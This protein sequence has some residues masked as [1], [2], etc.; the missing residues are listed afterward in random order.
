[1]FLIV[2]F[3]ASSSCSHAYYT[4]PCTKLGLHIKRLRGFQF[5]FCLQIDALIDHN[6]IEIV[7][8]TIGFE[9]LDYCVASMCIYL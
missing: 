8:T 9:F 2:Q 7:N 3:L 5:M 1:M 6:E 4:V